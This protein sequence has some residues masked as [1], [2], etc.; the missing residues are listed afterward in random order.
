MKVEA[1]VLKPMQAGDGKQGIKFAS[2][3][4][5]CVFSTV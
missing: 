3:I 5:F 4:A 2:Y 1:V